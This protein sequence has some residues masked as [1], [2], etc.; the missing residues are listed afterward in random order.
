MSKTARSLVILVLGVIGSLLAGCGGEQS[1][2]L[3]SL[4]PAEVTAGSGDLVLTVSGSH[5]RSD[6]KVLFGTTML[7][8]SSV[9]PT[10]LSVVVPAYVT[11]K[12]SV[13]D[14]SATGSATSVPLKFTIKNP[15]PTLVSLSSETVLLNSSS[16]LLEIAGTNF[17]SNTTASL[18]GQTLTPTSVSATRLTV[19]VPDSLLTTAQAMTLK[20]NNPSPGGGTSNELAFTVLNPIP[21]LSSFSIDNALVESSELMLDI[22]GTGFAPGI[23]VNFGA[24]SLTPTSITPQM[25]SILVPKE[26]LATAG[27]FSVT[28]A[29][30]TPG[31][32]V[33]N[34]LGFTVKNPVPVL[35]SI[36]LDNTLAGSTD[37][38]LTLT[39]TQFIASSTVGFGNTTLTPSAASPTELAVTVPASALTDGGIYPVTV[40]NRG[41]GGGA[42]NEI[43]FTVNN[44]APTISALSQKSALLGSSAFTLSITGTGFVSQ[45]YIQFGTVVL[46]PT[47]VTPTTVSVLVPGSAL[48]KSGPLYVSAV[49]PAPGGG[50]SEGLRFI[51]EN[52]VPE[53]TAV[54]P[55]SVNTSESSTT[56]TL[57][58]ASF[59]EGATVTLGT[60][61]LTPLSVTSSAI[62]IDVPATQLMSPGKLVFSV[63]NPEP[64]GG[65]S[66]PAT[67]T[68][69]G[70]AST[71]WRTV[72]NNR[73]N[74]PDS[75]KL[76]N[77]Y[78]QPSVNRR[79]MVVFKGQ[80]RSES[81]PTVGIYVRDMSTGGKPITKITDNSS[82]VPQPNNT[83][84]N[85]ALATFIQFPSFP[86]IDLDAD[87]VAFRGQSQPVWTYTLA[88]GS[89]TRVGST[90]VFSNPNGPLETAVNLL[91]TAP[92]Y[93][94]FQVPGAPVGTR[95]D[96][97]PGS[98][99][100]TDGSL[101][102]FK[103]NYTVDVGKTGIF[104]RSLSGGDGQTPVAVDVIANSETV[105]PGQP[106]GGTT[107]FG[108]TAPPSAANGRVMFVGLDNEEAPTM[109]GIYSAPITSRPELEP[110][111]TIGTQVP[112]EADGVTFSKFGEGLS[113]DGRYV[114][115]WASWGTE[116]RTRTLICGVDGNKEM[117]AICKATYPSGYQAEIPV[118]EGIF[119]YDTTTKQVIPIAKN[120][121]GEFN[122][123]VYWVFSGRPP[124]VG[125]SEGGDVPEPPRW[126][127]SAFTSVAGRAGDA[128]VVAFKANTGSV[129]GIYLAQG[130]DPAPIQTIIDT[131]FTGPSLDPEAPVGSAITSVGI[132][133]DGLRGN[134]LVLT[135]GML[136]SITSESNAGVYVTDA[137]PQ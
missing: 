15:V 25:I 70:R 37:L 101:I 71:N 116:M 81:G 93:E 75:S 26:A 3:S 137:M 32:G 131:T 14:V 135:S 98:P 6:T 125:N 136:D 53:L 63:T 31:G 78:N 95:F 104:F 84:Y 115:F 58:G 20:V 102:V 38:V 109:G 18:G 40:T 65:T 56:V 36:S 11:G 74:A 73:M 72:V 28:A 29:N 103:G 13:I 1:A 90:G 59:V 80:S 112:G 10:Q 34:S 42:S 130:P 83:M 126:R 113:F 92:G 9:T 7:T 97:F 129:D 107:V 76:F 47:S 60:E 30:V 105:I 66:G 39:G 45:T 35:S 96:Q 117:I 100:V 41:P 19:S 57:S 91:G 21:Q 79:G 27:V 52:P 61:Q 94:Y 99:A 16:V 77:S 86:R 134:W 17:V 22:N 124:N 118:H 23:T 89:E 12:A 106:E 87:T 122:D 44:P 121:N 54:S 108:S 132:E 46:V 51:V 64:G 82:T 2:L 67:L 111:V 4:T 120:S 69:H 33:S 85:G 128:F 68:V 114:A 119:V 62:T 48:T 88:D 24:V 55:T 5:F 110:I 50:T 133:R 43:S 127:S 123:F 8:P 49:N